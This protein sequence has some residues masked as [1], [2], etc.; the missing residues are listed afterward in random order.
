MTVHRARTDRVLGALDRLSTPGAVHEVQGGVQPLTAVVEVKSRHGEVVL[1]R[2]DADAE[3]EP[4]G[5]ELIEGRS[6]PGEQDG[7]PG[8]GEENIGHQ[9]DALGGA[10]RGAQRH[11]LVVA[12]VRDAPDRG[13]R[14]EAQL[15]GAPCNVD[16]QPAAVQALVRVGKSESDLQDF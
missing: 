2:T 8:W 13:K 9:A 11:E 7:L 1:S 14:R 16:Q 10:G 4:S 15:L 5:G 6:L 3:N 12:R